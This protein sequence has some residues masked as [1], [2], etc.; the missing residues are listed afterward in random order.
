MFKM[1]VV[2]LQVVN[3]QG[4]V[5]VRVAPQEFK[6]YKECIAKAPAA[7]APAEE[8]MSLPT[9]ESGVSVGCA[10]FSP[11]GITADK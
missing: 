10:K 4:Q 5:S 7:L 9:H 2:L 8:L 3:G 1:F 11:D 6:T